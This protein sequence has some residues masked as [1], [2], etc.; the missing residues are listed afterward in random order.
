MIVRARKPEPLPLSSIFFMWQESYT[1]Q[2]SK[3]W[4]PEKD[5][6][7]NLKKKYVKGESCKILNIYE[8]QQV[9]NDF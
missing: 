4:P 1:Q 3:I 8:E 7:K 5:N 2:I 6:M 9:I